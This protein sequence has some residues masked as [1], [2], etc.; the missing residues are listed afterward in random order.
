MPRPQ[1]L[2]RQRLLTSYHDPRRRL[3][4]VITIRGAAASLLLVDRDAFSG[5]DARLVAHLGSDEPPENASI[6]CA[7]YL[8]RL[9]R[10]PLV[11]RRLRPGDLKS[12]PDDGT[13]MPASAPDPLI[14]RDPAATARELPELPIVVRA[15]GPEP[16]AEH[17]ELRA[18][19]SAGGP[20]Q[21]RW[22]RCD[23]GGPLH[24]VSLRH[25]VAVL[26]SYEPV[27]RLTGLATRAD[28]Q[29]S[30]RAGEAISVSVLRA[31]LKRVLHSPIVLN[32]AVR[33]AVMERVAGGE[34][35]LSEIAI[36]CGRI[37]RDSAGNESGETSWLGRRLGLLPEG[38]KSSPTPWIHS[39]VLALIA[40]DGLGIPP[41][42]VEL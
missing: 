27:R 4:E 32:R 42:E 1:S 38:G 5:D 14:D 2:A 16:P 3:R 31:E 20:A 28:S 12:D 8:S 9:E 25:T 40:R 23:A 34:V 24:P 21:L 17:F 10:G 39:D 13:A 30:S 7:D 37:K 19:A 41:R 36:R 22:W 35:S 26:E 18:R 33:E 6:V 29:P 15:T 11:C